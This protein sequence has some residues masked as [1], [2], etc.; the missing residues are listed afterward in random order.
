MWYQAFAFCIWDGGRLPTEAEWEYVAAR[1]SENT[2]YPWGNDVTEPL[3]ANYAARHNTPFLS[4]GSE[5][6]GNGRWDHADLAGS[7]WE[8]VFDWWSD[9]YYTSTASGCSDCA[10]LIATSDRVLRGGFWDGDAHYARAANR[11]CDYPTTN[12]RSVGIR[13]ARDVN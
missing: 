9:T 11:D 10:N 5:P 2:V 8:W 6:L 1:G 7:M 3:P 4:V 12:Y 13:C